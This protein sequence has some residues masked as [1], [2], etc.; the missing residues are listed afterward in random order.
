MS[1]EVRTALSP[2]TTHNR[3][4]VFLAR[5]QN[6]LTH[7]IQHLLHLEGYAVVPLEE[8]R[9]LFE[10]VVAEQPDLVILD[11]HLTSKSPALCARMKDDPRM[12]G[13]PIIVVTDEPNSEEQLRCFAAGADDYLCLTES[14]TTL[15]LRVGALLRARSVSSTTHSAEVAAQALV[16]A[17]ALKDA[18]TA[19][20]MR[21]IERLAFALGYLMGLDREALLALRYGALLHDI[22]KLFVDAALLQKRGQLLPAELQA[23][24][25]HPLAGEQLVAQL[26]ALPPIGPIVRGH[27]ERWDGQGYPDGLAGAQI[28]LGARIVA[29]TDAFDAMTAVRPYHYPCD[30]RTAF[31]RLR[32]GA[33]SQWSA[34]IVEALIEHVTQAQPVKAA[35]PALARAVCAD[36]PVA[37]P[38][39]AVLLHG[40]VCKLPGL[41]ENH[42]TALD[43]DQ[44]FVREAL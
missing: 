15:E 30:Y 14:Y 12:R 1:D 33:G 16:R 11:I 32:E 24:R 21:R 9:P 44:P 34:D 3:P 31:V 39:D 43:A 6:A 2:A 41:E 20:H 37:T 38:A 23:M 35:A 4:R 27:H 7:T 26:A 42:R 13:I 17:M 18:G 8:H 5:R 10:Q 29:V 19:R 36:T 40:Q 28:P 25:R 22:G